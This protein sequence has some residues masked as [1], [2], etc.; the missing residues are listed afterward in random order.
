MSGTTTIGDTAVYWA[1]A[2]GP[3]I[4]S[5]QDALDLMGEAY[6]SGAD[7]IALPASRLAP[8][9]FRLRT[10]VA[11]AILQKLRNYGVRLAV[12]GDISAAVGASP[13]FADFVR[14]ANAGDFAFFVS[15]ADA[16]VR[17]LGGAAD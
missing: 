12:V 11:G 16:L 1:A 2:E 17:R 14:E 13:T 15:D 3:A 8:D 5:E 9:F 10:G 4:G 7:L 6:G